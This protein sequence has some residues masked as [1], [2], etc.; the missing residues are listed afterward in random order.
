VEGADEEVIV[1]S[2]E[3]HVNDV[4]AQADAAELAEATMIE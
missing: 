3:E 4:A 1:A 2:I